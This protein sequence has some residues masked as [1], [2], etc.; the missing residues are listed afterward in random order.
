MAHF[1]FLEDEALHCR[2]WLCTWDNRVESIEELMAI[3]FHAKEQKKHRE[4]LLEPTP[5]TSAHVTIGKQEVYEARLKTGASK[6]EHRRAIY[7]L[8]LFRWELYGPENEP[9]AQLSYLPQI[10]TY[11]DKW[12][13]T[14]YFFYAD[15]EK[16]PAGTN[17][18]NYPEPRL[19]SAVEDS[20]L[21]IPVAKI[22][23]A[24]A[25][26]LFN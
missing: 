6:A 24:T 15:R 17:E 10:F 11:E 4:V 21:P 2:R 3:C 16:A 5:L 23:K 22:A 1:H 8:A 13:H 20:G 14:I 7:E 26:K 9:L 19:A 18:L 25:V 12:D